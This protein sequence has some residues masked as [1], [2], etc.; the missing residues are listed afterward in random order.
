MFTTYVKRK[1]YFLLVFSCLILNQKVSGQIVIGTPSLGFSQACANSNFNTFA[2]SFVFSP[3]SGL[4]NSNQFSIELS[5]A[6]GDFSNPSVI[7]TSTP[8]SITTSPATLNFS[9]PTTTAGENH[10]IRIK[11]SSPVATSANSS[12]FAAYFKIHDSPF[13]INNLLP[14]GIYCTNGNYLLTIDNPGT[15]TN[16][17]PLNYGSLTFRWFKVTSPTTSIYISQGNTLTV[18]QEG[19][20]FAET[21]YGSCT[22]NSFS[23]RVTVNSID[24]G[25]DSATISSSLG[26]PFC[27]DQGG[28][29]LTTILGNSYQWYKDGEAI[30]NATLQNFEATETG[31]YTVQINLGD[32]SVSASIDII[33]EL[34]Q[35]SINVDEINIMDEGDSLLITISNAANNPTFEWYYNNVLIPG[36]TEDNFTAT[37]IGNYSVI[38][39]ENT[40]CLAST[41]Y[42]FELV[43]AYNP[44]PDV[45]KIPNLISP[46]GDTINDTWVLPL[47]YVTG[48]NTQVTILSS[49]GKIMLQTNEYQ[50]NW[51]STSLNPTSISQLYYYIITTPDGE[52]K[53][54]SITIIK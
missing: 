11:S 2:T 33:S 4:N 48:T 40:G 54:G 18:T 10:K 3:E 15:G 20:Y 32:C 31:F 16:D 1:L 28:T 49:R 26:S 36:A 37:E 13:T 38:I 44:F 12:S 7:Y 22:S 29:I 27:P 8:G 42:L 35:S 24:S 9:L 25:S 50:N 19:T 45:G 53:K 14:T 5:D 21:N 52:T 30:T 23:N 34:F 6:S 17:S 51:P 43:E 39:Y 41:T 46:N 47:K